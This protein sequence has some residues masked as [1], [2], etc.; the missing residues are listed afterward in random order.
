MLKGGSK[1]NDQMRP[2]D[3][4]RRALEG[5]RAGMFLRFGEKKS[6]AIV[7]GAACG[8][9][10]VVVIIL[11]FFLIRIGSIE[12]TGD[13]TM[14]NEGEIIAAAEI[15]E[16]D[17][18]FWR[19]ASAIRKSIEKNM[20]LAQN[21]KVEKSLFG[22]VTIHVELDS[23]D[24]Y[25]EYDG[26]YYAMSD[27][28]RVLDKS[29]SYRKYTSYGAVK[30]ILPEIREPS[31]GEKIVF[32]YTVEETDTEGETLYEVEKEK[33]Y[34]YVSGFLTALK[35]SGYREDA[36]GVILDEKFDVT[37]IYAEKFKVR[38]GTVDQL[39]VKFRMLYEIFAEGSLQ[40]ADKAEVDLSDP[41]AAIA[42]PNPSLDFSDFV[43]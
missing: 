26:N 40:Y 1:M 13:V 25:F 37:L 6:K 3:K 22:K 7:I 36:N 12:V 21:I 31:I 28:L 23:V 32:Y 2:E 9:V 39:D 43:D 41:S 29:D 27:S 15:A 5:L 17:G 10:A 24:Y 16:G 34:D 35:E 33:K 14:F 19:S 8:F 38:F 11:S 42:R 30:V 18:L 4:A 20:P